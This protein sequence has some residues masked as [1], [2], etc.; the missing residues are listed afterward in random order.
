MQAWVVHEYGDYKD[1]LRWEAFPAPQVRPDHGVIRVTGAG[2]S[3][4]MMLKIAG[5]YQVRDPLPFVPG[6]EVAGVVTEA[7]EGFPYAVGQ[8]VMGLTYTGCCCEY[9][10]LQTVN[11]FP[12]PDEMS[13]AHAAAFLNAYQTAYL[14]LVDR[15]RVQPGET[16][17]V[18]SGAGGVGLAAVQIASALGARVL[19]T[20]GSAEKLAVCREHGAEDA[21][22]YTAGPF[23]EAVQAATGGRGVDVVIDPVGG[24]AFDQGLRCLAWNGRM[25]VIGFTSGQIPQVRVNRLLLGNIATLGLLRTTYPDHAP[26][27]IRQ[28]QEHLV[29]LYRQGRVRPVVSHALP[30][31][32]LPRAIGLVESRR[33]HGKVIVTL[34][35]GG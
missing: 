28:C 19:A 27:L 23:V 6:L 7:G 13:D 8:R 18:N 15:A 20:A 9:A 29:H 31:A 11:T 12:V 21:F 5:K 33:A 3:F 4:A 17:L 14:G 34:P 26:V 10:A 2:I 35:A 16:V 1:V 24:E 32:E 22:D 30:M 25:V